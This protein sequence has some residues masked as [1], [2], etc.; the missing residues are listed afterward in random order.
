M[1]TVG[2]D[3]VPATKKQRL[4]LLIRRGTDMADA[5]RRREDQQSRG[6]RSSE[7]PAV[8]ATPAAAAAMEP[9][10]STH[11]DQR[12]DARLRELVERYGEGDWR[13]IAAELGPARSRKRC[14]ERY[15]NHLAPAL[16]K[17][18]WTREEHAQAI[19]L[20]REFGSKW[21]TIARQ[22]EGR[23]PDDVKNRLRLLTDAEGRDRGDKAALGWSQAET[24]ALRGLV[25]KHGA[26]NWLLI[27]SQLPGGRTDQ[28]CMQHWHRVA[29]EAIVKGRGSWT[30]EEDALL[31]SKVQELGHHWAKV[32]W[33]SCL[34]CR[35]VGVDAV[36]LLLRSVWL[37]QIAQH[38]PGRVGKQ[39]RERFL[40]HVDPSINKVGVAS[41]S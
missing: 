5:Q 19:A 10:R 8:A 30:A 25:R 9:T 33:S 12:D 29:D 17:A 7:A 40:N 2:G 21:A 4:A 23:G 14:R 24:E 20:H 6:G 11:W 32:R 26:R 18:P 16:H 28:Q 39:C 1:E 37:R 13:R 15:V 22:M 34:T 35:S 36:W 31:L 41:Q 38:L 3:G 27:A